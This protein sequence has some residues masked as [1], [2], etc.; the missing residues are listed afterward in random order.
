MPGSLGSLLPNRWVR[1]FVLA[2]IPLLFFFFCSGLILVSGMAT[3][4]SVQ[5]FGDA[6]AGR[7]PTPAE[8]RRGTVVGELV[9]GSASALRAAVWNRRTHKHEAPFH[10][11]LTLAGSGRRVTLFDGASGPGQAVEVAFRVPP[12]PAGRY[13]ATLAVRRDR[14][15]LQAGWA[16]DVVEPGGRRAAVPLEPAKASSPPAP[17]RADPDGIVLDVLP[18][19]G[20][21]ILAE[22]G[23]RF[24]I[25]TMH[26]SGRPIRAR[27]D[28]TLQQGRLDAT[29]EGQ[30]VAGPLHTDALGLHAFPAISRHPALVL[31]GRYQRQELD[32]TAGPERQAEHSFEQR[33]THAVLLPDRL[34]VPPGKRF[35]AAIRLLS[36]SGTSY[37]EVIDRTGHRVATSA[38][39]IS[40]R[41]PRI[42]LLAPETPGLFSVQLTD[43]FA[44][45][46]TAL[47]R[48]TLFA[49][50][51]GLEAPGVLD[52]IARAV[53]AELPAGDRTRAHLEALVAQ[54]LLRGP[55]AEPERTAAYLLSRLDHLHHPP[56]WLVD[57]QAAE[58]SLLRERQARLRG[59]L[60]A[61]LAFATLLLLAVVI[62]LVVVNLGISRQAE[63]EREALMAD[64]HREAGLEPPAPTPPQPG[65]ER[66]QRLFQMG[67]VVGL[68]L[69][70]GAAMLILLLRL[71]WGWQ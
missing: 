60:V 31:A 53:A 51:A 14:M 2:A 65:V 71:S 5:V 66:L 27:V 43:D 49:D 39:E 67:M 7:A 42:G 58:G 23:E 28:L 55:V 20:T 47:V 1:R 68:V 59:I 4:H 11:R 21:K 17:T 6:R 35:G 32:G 8:L 3:T 10:A 63:R 54:G 46:G 45:P 12:L 18:S 57:T 50:P 16:V 24:F 19:S 25:R 40:P 36:K 37:A 30:I 13:R 15:N 34:V 29:R 26:T 62:P 48:R 9:S 64:F 61:G 33:A 41:A 22:L 44:T 69:L 70:T 38:Q 56:H 52:R